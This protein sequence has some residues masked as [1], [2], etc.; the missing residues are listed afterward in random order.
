MPN[1]FILAGPNGAGKTTSA[2]A[3]LPK[4]LQCVEFVNAD[5]IAA[6]LSPFQPATVALEAG[7]LM[8]NRIKKLASEKKDF[9]FETTLA[10]KTFA[11]FLKTCQSK[12][13]TDSLL[14]IW[15]SSPELAIKRVQSRVANGG[16][17]IPEDV[18]K[19]RYVRSISN[20]FNLYL[21]IVTNCYI[22]DNSTGTPEE[23]A[24][25]EDHGNIT[26]I[27]QKKWTALRDYYE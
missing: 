11:P 13:F 24:R 27:S 9:A 26:I 1:I 19:R 25:K 6:G 2:M 12:G 10:S 15:L 14:Y 21:P 5:V 22:F 4:K 20:L 3:L 7:R 16:H 17:D 23:I 8:I 18:I